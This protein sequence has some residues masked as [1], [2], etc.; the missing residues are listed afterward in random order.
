MKLTSKNRKKDDGLKP[1]VVRYVRLFCAVAVVTVAGVELW[2]NL[3]DISA[4]GIGGAAGATATV[5]AKKFA[6]VA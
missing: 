5:L 6:L 3:S 4:L 2:S 1:S